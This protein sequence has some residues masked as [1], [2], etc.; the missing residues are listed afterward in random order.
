MAKT[1]YPTEEQ[2][3][4]DPVEPRRGHRR[5]PPLAEIDSWELWQAWKRGERGVVLPW[6]GLL[7]GFCVVLASMYSFFFFSTSVSDDTI[8]QVVL[9][10]VLIAF[11]FALWRRISARRDFAFMVV[12]LILAVSGATFV[13][14]LLA[15]RLSG[16][17]PWVAIGGTLGLGLAGMLIGLPSLNALAPRSGE[18]EK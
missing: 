2:Q 3:A 4:Q 6:V 10:I 5:R 14:W 1:P 18:E 16:W 12:A 8:A 9:T 7:V 15:Y 13:L 17:N 11:L